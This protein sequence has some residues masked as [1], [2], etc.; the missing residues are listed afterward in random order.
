MTAHEINNMS[1]DETL[2]VPECED[3][4][5]LINRIKYGGSSGKVLRALQKYTCSVPQKTMEE[6]LRQGVV[7]NIIG[8][9]NHRN[10]SHGGVFALKTMDYYSKCMGIMTEGGDYYV[11]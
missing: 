1:R 10:S 3:A 7:E 11:D 9:E 4:E 8:S 2:I 5:N 6:L